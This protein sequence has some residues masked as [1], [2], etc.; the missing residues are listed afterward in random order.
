MEACENT[1]RLEI[2]RWEPRREPRPRFQFFHRPWQSRLTVLGLLQEV[3]EEHDSSL[4][5]RSSCREGICGACA[6]LVNGRYRLACATPV[7][8]LGTK[9]ITVAPLPRLRVIK[10]LV[11]DLEPFWRAHEAVR[12]YLTPPSGP[13]GGREFLQS[14]RDRERMGQ[15]IACILCGSCFSACP[16]HWTGK[17]DLG[18]AALTRTFRFYADSRDGDGAA[19]LARADRGLWRCRYALN[20]TDACPRNVNPAHHIRELR[21]QAVRSW[22]GRV[23]RRT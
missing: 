22:L 10:D 8:D 18:P 3:Y 2:Y 11:V 21:R 6:M 23:T 14:P 7:A 5:F 19:R 16:T 20:C 13:P 15:A 12:P 1:I 17:H 4:A 9:C